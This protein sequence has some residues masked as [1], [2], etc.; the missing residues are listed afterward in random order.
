M[1]SASLRP[2][3]AVMEAG[4]SAEPDTI[5][6]LPQHK[7]DTGSLEAYLN[8]HLSG[9][10]A[11]PEAQLT[12]A[13]YRYRRRPSPPAET[14]LYIVLFFLWPGVGSQFP[15]SPLFLH[16][17]TPQVGAAVGGPLHFILRISHSRTVM[18]APHYS[19]FQL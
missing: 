14:N 7:F 3:E 2:A 5:E 12:V 10:G 17:L 1:E 15:P 18:E 16:R 9:F 6:V 4:A 19:G 13:Q 11:E 8:Q